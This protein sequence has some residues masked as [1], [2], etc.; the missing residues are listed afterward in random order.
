M[1]WLVAI[2][3]WLELLAMAILFRLIILRR[4]FCYA[5]KMGRLFFLLAWRARLLLFAIEGV[6][7]LG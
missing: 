5:L 4:L 3:V 7:Q 1:F 2:G 6:L